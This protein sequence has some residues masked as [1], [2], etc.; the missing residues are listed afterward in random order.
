VCGWARVGRMVA[1]AVLWMADFG[2]A[3]RA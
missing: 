1:P 2:I 3:A